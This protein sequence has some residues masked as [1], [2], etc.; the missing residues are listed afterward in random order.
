MPESEPLARSC[1]GCGSPFEVKDPVWVE[2]VD[3]SHTLVLPVALDAADVTSRV[4]HTAGYVAQR[5]R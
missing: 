3:D 4:W 1:V 5:L 2:R